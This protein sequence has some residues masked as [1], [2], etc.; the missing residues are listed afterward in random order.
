M[1]YERMLDKAHRPTEKEILGTIGETAIWLNLR[2]YIEEHYAVT[3]EPKFYANKYGW[4]IRSRRSSKTL[5]SLFPEQ[6]AFSALIVL[7]KKEAKQALSM[8]DEFGPTVRAVLENTKQSHDGRWLWI[9]V[10]SNNDADDVKR[11]LNVKQRAGKT[12]A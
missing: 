1:S 9:R 11:L 8:L 10:L 3:P 2:Q 5:C 6:G 4:T 7:G 12:K